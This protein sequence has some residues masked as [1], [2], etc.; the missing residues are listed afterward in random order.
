MDFMLRNDDSSRKS[1]SSFTNITC[2]KCHK[3]AM[4]EKKIERLPDGGTLIKAMH[5]DGKQC[6]WAEYDTIEDV[7]E[8]RKKEKNPKRIVC[9][10]CSKRGRINHYYKDDKKRENVSYLVVHEPIGGEWGRKSK[11][12]R[13]RRCYINDSKD[14]DII[15]KKLGRYIEKDD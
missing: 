13:V 9:P 11:V 6:S 12:K 10:A 8:N 2:I 15:L 1:N 4:G 14:R 3:E 7:M 5:A